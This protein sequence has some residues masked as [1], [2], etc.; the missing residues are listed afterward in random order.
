VVNPGVIEKKTVSGELK[1][2]LGALINLLP[3]AMEEVHAAG[4]PRQSSG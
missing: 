3:K 2:K 1:K 4:I